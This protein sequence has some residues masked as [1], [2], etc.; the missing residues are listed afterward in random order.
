MNGTSALHAAESL[1]GSTPNDTGRAPQEHKL[2]YDVTRYLR[3]ATPF[4]VDEIDL[5]AGTGMQPWDIFCL[6]CDNPLKQSGISHLQSDGSCP[7]P[8]IHC[9]TRNH[10]D[11]LCSTL[12][13]SQYFQTR[14]GLHLEVQPYLSVRPSPEDL[15]VISRDYPQYRAFVASVAPI[16][17]EEGIESVRDIESINEMEPTNEIKPETRLAPEEPSKS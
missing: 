10:Q 12:W 14:H 6:H 3:P 4:V 11:L 13:L 7:F 8:C 17:G 5:F 9:N 1:G 16:G 15:R 2:E